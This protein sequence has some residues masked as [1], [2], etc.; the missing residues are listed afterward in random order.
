MKVYITLLGRSTWALLN[1]FYASVDKGYRPDSVYVFVEESFSEQTEKV[2]KGL[3]I[4]SDGFDFSPEIETRIVD[5]VDFVTAAGDMEEILKKKLIEENEVAIDITPGRK[6]LVT[7]ALLSAFYISEGSELN[8]ESIRYLA[9]DSLKNASKPY[10][11][12]SL[13]RQK[14]KDLVQEIRKNKKS[15]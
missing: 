9:I 3:N 10:Y 15:G 7:A 2:V 5:D 1:S 13:E 6:A 14:L 8:I 12:I 4:I 11:E